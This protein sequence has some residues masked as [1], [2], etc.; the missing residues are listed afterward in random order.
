MHPPFWY[1]VGHA[2]KL[3]YD[4]CQP[5]PIFVQAAQRNHF[6]W[7]I[8]SHANAFDI[9]GCAPSQLKT[10]IRR[11]PM[12]EAPMLEEDFTKGDFGW[13]SN[14][15][16]G[17]RS[18]RW[19]KADTGGVQPDMLEFAVSRAAGWGTGATFRTRL[20]RLDPHPRTDDILEIFK[21]WE[22]VKEKNM[23]SEKQKAALRNPDQEHILLRNENSEFEL[24]PYDQISQVPTDKIR[25]FHFQRKGKVYIVYWH[26]RGEGRFLLPVDRKNIKLFDSLFEEPLDLKTRQGKVVLPAG[27]R[28]YLECTDLSQQQVIEAF[29]NLRLL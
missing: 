5:S 1:H 21:R 15:P 27:N 10:I 23:L 11:D 16:P 13:I 18:S 9:Q 29:R 19:S 24:R 28:R 8:V 26:T 17:F 3:T 2:I 6:S 20:A 4:Q 22:T 12:R 7:H 25:A 14:H